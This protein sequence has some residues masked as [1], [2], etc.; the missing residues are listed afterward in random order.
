M[1]TQRLQAR[2]SKGKCPVAVRVKRSSD[3]GTG[4]LADPDLVRPHGAF[5][6]VLAPNGHLIVAHP[7]G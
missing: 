2:G 1:Q 5:N 3:G 4:T 6:L 7:E